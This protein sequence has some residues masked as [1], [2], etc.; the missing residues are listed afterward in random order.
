MTSEDF[1]LLKRAAFF[2]I[3]YCKIKV[4]INKTS[5]GKYFGLIDKVKRTV[6][7]N[8]WRVL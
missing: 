8:L 6:Y 7:V 2:D 3:E 1:S 5:Y 4:R